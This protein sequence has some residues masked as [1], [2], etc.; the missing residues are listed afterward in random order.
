MCIYL[1][2]LSH[3]L[4]FRHNKLNGQLGIKTVGD[5]LETDPY[6]FTEEQWYGHQ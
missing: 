1:S 5:I 4:P 3:I 2:V 6:F